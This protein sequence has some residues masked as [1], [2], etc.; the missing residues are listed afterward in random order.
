MMR[1]PGM[2]ELKQFRGMEIRL[3]N[4]RKRLQH[5]SSVAFSIYGDPDRIRTCGPK[6]LTNYNFRYHLP[7]RLCGLD[8]LFIIGSCPQ[9]LPVK[10]LHL[11][12]S[13][14]GSGLPFYRSR[15]GFPEFE[16][17]HHDVSS[18]GAQFYFRNLVLY[19][20][21]LQGHNA[22][23]YPYLYRISTRDDNPKLH[24]FI[25]HKKFTK[26]KLLFCKHFLHKNRYM[27]N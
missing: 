8:F 23:F 12:V 3:Q 10:S 11:P 5:I 15:E 14:L 19:P 17:I 4:K 13:R 7:R 25:T 22:F 18:H 1:E 26:Y 27:Y 20:A 9:M 21:E 6:I 16:Q 2:P 24:I